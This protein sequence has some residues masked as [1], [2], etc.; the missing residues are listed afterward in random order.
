M[1]KSTCVPWSSRWTSV[2]LRAQRGGQHGWRLGGQENEIERDR[3]QST[4]DLVGQGRISH[5]NQ[6][7]L[8]RHRRLLSKGDIPACVC[9]NHVSCSPG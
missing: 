2:L 8:R 7:I 6:R 1:A 4:P 3:D 5:V 9:Y